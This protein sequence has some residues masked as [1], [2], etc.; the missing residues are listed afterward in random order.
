[1]FKWGKV[2]GTW[3]S[4]KKVEPG[5]RVELHE[6]DTLQLGGSTRVYRLHWMPLSLAYDMKNPFVPTLEASEAVHV[7]KDEAQPHLES[8]LP[9]LKD[10]ESEFQDDYAE[11]LDLLFSD[12]DM[13]SQ[14]EQLTSYAPL[15]LDNTKPPFHYEAAENNSSLPEI[16][17]LSD[18]AEIQPVGELGGLESNL[19]HLKDDEAEFQDDYVEGLDFLF[20]DM[21]MKSQMEQLTSYAPLLFHY[22]AAE[23]N[24]SLPEILHLSDVAEIQPVGELGGLESDVLHLE[25]NETEIHGDYIEGLDLL[26]SDM[27]MK[28]P[29]EQLNSYASLVLEDKEP[30]LYSA[31][32][33]NNSS[34]LETLQLSDIAEIVPVRELGGLDSDALHL[35]DDKT[36]FPGEY[37]E[38]LDLLFSDMNLM[39]PMSQLTAYVPRELEDTKLP[40]NFEKDAENKCSF[41]ETLKL[42]EIAETQPIRQLDEKKVDLE[43]G[44]LTSAIVMNNSFVPFNMPE[45]VEE[46]EEAFTPDKE[47]MLPK[48]RL[49]LSSKKQERSGKVNCPNIYRASPLKNVGSNVCKE[50]PKPAISE[51]SSPSR[52]VLEKELSDRT[53]SSRVAKSDADILKVREHRI[54]FQSLPVSSNETALEGV[55]SKGTSR[56]CKTV[57]NLQIR[58]SVL[59]FNNSKGKIK[60]WTMVADTA[61]LLDKESRKALQLMQGL[62]GTSLII[63]RIVIRELE[64]MN[65]H[66]YLFRRNTVVSSALQWIKGCME[67]TEW[68]IR[69][70]SSAK[71]AEQIAPTPR[72]WPLP[73]TSEEKEKFSASSVPSS[74]FGSFLEILTP[75]A[76]DHIL[77]CALSIRNTLP[78]G[79]LVLLSDD[80]SLKIKAMAEGL[81]CETAQEFRESLVNPFSSRFLW[82]DSSPR[83]PTWSCRDEVVLRE[84]YCN[85]PSRKYQRL[86]EVAKGLKLILLHNS[87]YRQMSS[88]S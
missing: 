36:E 65:K 24:S 59:P 39:S 48:T 28:S 72:T 22:E 29:M 15:R 8:N 41:Q 46:G 86:G 54:P 27:N 57:V 66:C 49:M 43:W 60:T 53:C 67:N 80:V 34:L 75:T 78:K 38:G 81:L 3:V 69:V 31:H 79:Q 64:H 71:D 73:Q 47:N 52:E 14:M 12:M 56:G 44:P 51:N 6:G 4:G 11:G 50:V 70:Q 83:G 13:K 35:Q 68:W 1:M 40:F 2:H 37:F 30:P 63:P 42:S 5:V 23:N 21:D 9:H 84:K 18:V 87:Q 61:S 45:P 58:E 10:D 7:S 88:I 77:D 85:V 16:L 32:A 55:D 82:A 26:F 33:E 17:H 62:R 19:P 25:N 20:A 74:P 76:E